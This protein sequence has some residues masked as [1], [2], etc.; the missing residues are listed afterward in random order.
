MKPPVA[1]RVDLRAFAFMPLV[2]AELFN[3]DTWLLACRHPFAAAACI[4]L[5]G[6]AWH[7]VPAGS[8]P[9]DEALLAGYAGVPDWAAV[10]DI[11]LRGFVKAD[12]G[13][14]YH[15]KLCAKVKK[16]WAERRSYADFCK[17]Q[18]K[19][20]VRANDK[21][22]NSKRK[23]DPPRGDPRGDRPGIP[24]ASPDDPLKGEGEGE[25]KGE[26]PLLKNAPPI[27]DAEPDAGEPDEQTP[28]SPDDGTRLPPDWRLDPEGRAFAAGLGYAEPAIDFLAAQFADYWRAKPG[29]GARKRDWGLTWQVWCRNYHGPAGPGPGGPGGAQALRGGPPGG[30][31]VAALGEVRASRERPGVVGKPRLRF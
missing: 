21:R 7:Q 25:G 27:L 10:R 18:K 9:D 31:V 16:A 6:R 19:K 14:L 24:E 20:S 13:R 5:W 3:S 8:L 17:S 26:A 15:K 2:I 29:D 4:N 11:A 12:D 22:W 23:M 28:P 30:G 1:A